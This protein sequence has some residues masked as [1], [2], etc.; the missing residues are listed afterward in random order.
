MNF[1]EKKEQIRQWIKENIK[2]E[3]YILIGK[4]SINLTGYFDSGRIE[5]AEINANLQFQMILDNEEP[6][7]EITY[8]ELKFVKDMIDFLLETMNKWIM[9]VKNMFVECKICGQ[10]IEANRMI[11]L[12]TG[13]EELMCLKCLNLETKKAYKRLDELNRPFLKFFESSGK[14]WY[15]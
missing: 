9:G 3:D 15:T 7:I 11:M 6:I 14:S 12:M 2:R 4:Q 10:I 8:D 13:V 5:Y 1:R